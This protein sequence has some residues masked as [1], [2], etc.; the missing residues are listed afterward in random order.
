MGKK[1]AVVLT[2]L[3][4][5]IEYTAPVKAY[6]EKG[7]EIENVGIKKGEVVEGKKKKEKVTIDKSVDEVSSKDY[8]ALLIPG[9]FSPDI[10]R[11]NDNAVNFAKG[12]MN[13]K[14]PV[15]V[16]C[17]GPQLLINSHS[18]KGKKA[19][20]VKSIKIDMINAGADFYDKEVV[21][22]DNLVSSRTPKDMEA[23][24]RESVKLLE[25]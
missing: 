12:F 18:L 24:I 8:D 20:G 4:E 3:F 22:D 17:H 7:H 23:F 15:F 13:E 2:K 14:K 1:I 6:K 11:S 5:D 10:L 25:K 19:T 21:V 16:I 9:G